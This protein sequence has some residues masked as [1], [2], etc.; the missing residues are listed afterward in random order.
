[1]FRRGI[2]AAVLALLATALAAPPDE[3][4]AGGAPADLDAPHPG[5]STVL[6]YLSVGTIET[7]A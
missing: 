4:A 7:C 2:V 1:M 5:G 3:P 6:A